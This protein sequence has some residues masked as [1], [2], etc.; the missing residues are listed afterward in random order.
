MLLNF[1]AN[2]AK[3][4]VSMVNMANN[5]E[6]SL[7][8]SSYYNIAL[9]QIMRASRKGYT[10]VC[11]YLLPEV[12]ELVLDSLREDGYRIGSTDTPRRFVIAWDDK[13]LAKEYEGE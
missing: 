12:H 1:S 2:S 11:I 7:L 5:E 6:T 8:A 10:R 3:K 4:Q 9:V 13:P